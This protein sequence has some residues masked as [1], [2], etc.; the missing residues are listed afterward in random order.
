VRKKLLYIT[1]LFVA[2]VVTIGYLTGHKESH[3]VLI[4][5]SYEPT[6]ES[7]QKLT[8]LIIKDLKSSGVNADV[9][10]FYLNCESYLEKDEIEHMRYLLDSVSANGWKPDVILVNDDQATYSL[11]KSNHSLIS[12]T[13]IVFSGVNYPNWGLIKEFPNITGFQDSIDVYKNLLF[14]RSIHKSHACLF[15]VLDYTFLDRKVREDIYKTAKGRRI[16]GFMTPWFSNKEFTRLIKSRRYIVLKNFNARGVRGVTGISD[17]LIYEIN[18]EGKNC[19]FIKFKRDFST[20]YLGLLNPNLSFTA[21]NE[22]FGVDLNMLGGYFTPITIQAK[23]QVDYAIK[24]LHGT[25]PKDLPIIKSKKEYLI[26]W[27]VMRKFHL[28]FKDFPS[29]CKFTNITFSQRHPIIATCL[30]TLISLSLLLLFVY[31]YLIY[32][33]ERRRKKIA[34]AAVTRERKILKLALEGSNT[35]VWTMENDIISFEDSLWKYIHKEP[36]SISSEE[37]IKQIHPSQQDLFKDFLNSTKTTKS[38]ELLIALDKGEYQWWTVRCTKSLSPEGHVRTTGLVFNI[39][40]YKDKE[41]E[42]RN[43]RILA[44]K[45]EMKQSFFANMSHE[46]RTPLN[47][48]LGF[49]GILTDTENLTKEE[50][51]E[52]TNIIKNNSKGPIKLN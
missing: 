49:T 42:L 23:D 43:A 14:P 8:S 1:I 20:V 2:I 3:R 21:I 12:H 26:D 36:R 45:A 25:S 15:T 24:I 27:K 6:C 29:Y 4:I 47:A 31:M 10:C 28:D 39:Q 16:I 52:Y 11:M 30:Y 13:P 22:E 34:Y 5:Q 7:S 18:A 32:I 17:N 48:I 50:R 35:F 51:T 9:R 19:D 41:E 40:E 44:E 37:L 33:R 38:T 46:I